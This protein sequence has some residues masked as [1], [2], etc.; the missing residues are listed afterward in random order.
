M[1]FALY[2][3][4]NDSNINRNLGR[5]Q[6]SYY[7][8]LKSFRRIFEELGQVVMISQPYTQVD[9]VYETCQSNNEHC[10]FVCFTPP[11]LAPIDLKCPTMCLFAWEFSTIPSASWDGN[12]ANN[13]CYVFSHHSGVIATSTY[14]A[15]IIRQA[16]NDYGAEVPVLPIPSPAWDDFDCLRARDPLRHLETGSRISAPGHLQDS[17]ET[18]F[19]LRNLLP[20]HF[21]E[22]Q[23]WPKS[24]AAAFP[25][26][27]PDGFIARARASKM[28]LQN[29]YREVIQRHPPRAPESSI[30]KPEKHEPRSVYL[31]IQGVVYTT[32]LN[33]KDGR[34]CHVDLLTAFIWAFREDPGVTLI[35]KMSQSNA[36]LYRFELNHLLHQLYPFRCRVIIFN[37]FLT[38]DQYRRLVDAS[39]FYVNTSLCEGLCIPLMEFLSSGKL[40]IAP[41]H[42]AMK[43]YVNEEVA[44]VIESTRETNVWPHDP[45]GHYTTERF[46][47]NWE[48]IVRAYRESYDLVSRNPAE[49]Q[50]KSRIAKSQM[51][52][53]CS[54]DTVKN[55]MRSFIQDVCGFHLRQ[56]HL[57]EKDEEKVLKLT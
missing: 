5:P 23:S 16:L 17:S 31:D 6:Y 40:V 8:L 30:L 9:K 12:P 49:Y 56:D 2:S 29:W 38:E 20:R 41:N 15:G 37:G 51:R 52:E 54:F 53:F 3:E 48:S 35:M 14:T 11:H 28:H 19:N 4:L 24:Q 26:H 42:T 57:P 50:N 45:R 1:I 21:T 39:T 43:D 44:F 7:F 34:K 33:P 36:D 22:V 10:L 32:V 27:S 47:N 46:R 55:R 18:N 13:W 25:A